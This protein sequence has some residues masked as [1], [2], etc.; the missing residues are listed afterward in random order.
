MVLKMA[1]YKL[2]SERKKRICELDSE[3]I[4]FYRRNPCIACEELLGIKLIDS[5][6]YILQASW[7]KPHVLWCCS[8]NFG[9][10]FLGAIFMILK[11]ILYENQAIY[12]VSSVGDQSKETF[13]K[14]EE[15]VLRI[16][17]TA[18]SI[19]SL[20]DIV[21]KETKK[22]G[23]N[24]TGFGHAQSGFHVEFYNG[25]EIF[26][27]N[28]NPDN[29]RSRRATLVFFDEA[30]FSSDELIAVCEAFATQNTEFKTSVAKDFNPETLK[31]KCPTQLVYASSQ[32]D[33]SKIFYQHYKNFTKKMIA[34]DR[35]Y[36]V[37]DMIC[38][39]AIKTFMEGKP[40]TALLTQDKVDAAMKANREKALREYY[41]QPT[42]DGGVNQ[43]VKWGTIRRNESFYL[44]QLCY[45]PNT[46]IALALDPARTLDNSILSAMNIINDKDYG[47][48]GEI[49]N[50]VNFVDQTSK[51]GY[52]LDSNR[53]LE[54]IRNYLD[55]YNGMHN[56][57]QN[58]DILLIDQ[59]SGGGGT[60]TYADGLL[61]DWVGRDGRKHRGLIDKSHEIYKGYEQLYPNAIDKLRLI[62]P[63]KYRTQMVDEFI[64]LM[65][66]GVIKFPYEFKQEFI[67]MAKKE[68]D[69]TETIENYQ[70]S[71]EEILTLA[72][73]DLM[74]SEITS[75]Y[76]Y[77]NAE[78]TSKSYALA[79]DKESKM[80]DDRFYTVIMLAHYLYDLRRGQTVT[81]DKPKVN[82][83]SA[84]TFASSIDF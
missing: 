22:S 28:G 45:K 78:K 42:R 84:P 10:S 13:S 39:T 59:G 72:N 19:D 27:L 5:Q 44:P 74:K 61:N 20:K 41:N 76:K 6:K 79:K 16:G 65:N 57:Y 2:M 82:Y 30:A 56:D 14:I 63:K 77:E 7:N 37:V 69:D 4:A 1:Y 83:S 54:E 18:A 70:L 36:I 75:I 9:K 46:R 32:D 40:Y 67:A 17:K 73:I 60:S 50:C 48:M 11:A 58:I 55:T 64:E 62:N 80:H 26:T 68:E 43:I 8:R 31:R 33:M 21:E 81:T 34:G 53:Q 25:S 51:K 29:N 49:V 3:S 47:Y 24:K 52:K 71:D 38:D 66:L 12:I 23:N 15:I 35:D